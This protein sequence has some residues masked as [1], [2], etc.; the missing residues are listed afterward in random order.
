VTVHTWTKSACVVFAWS[1]LLI[2][3][4]TTGVTGPARPPEAN[5]HIAGKTTE[6]ILTSMSDA[7][8]APGPTTGYVV[9]PGDTLSSIAA[10]FAVRG[11]WP[12]LYA[13][14]RPLI[15]PDPNLIRPGA[16]LVLPGQ[17]APVRYR[18]VPGD[19]LAGIAAAL[20]VHGGWPALYAANRPLIGPDPNVIH[21]GAVLM[22]PRP[23]APSR[24]ASGPAP[25]RSPAPPSAPAHTRHNPLPGRTGAPV[26][27]GM[28]QWLKILLAAG[29]L[30]AAAFVAG[31]M[32]AVRRR[33]QTVRRAAPP[34]NAGSG[35]APGGERPD[36][37]TARIVV[38]D[39]DR[40]VVACNRSGGTA[41]VLRPPG[42]DPREILRVARLVLPQAWYA[43]LAGRL[44]FPAGWPIVVADHDRLVVACS[45]PGGTVY[46]LRPPGTDPREILRVARLVL[47][48]APY[49]ELAELLG[50]SAGWPVQHRVPAKPAGVLFAWALL[51]VLAVGAGLT[52]PTRLAKA[53]ARTASSTPEVTITSMPSTAAAPDPASGQAAGYVVQP[54]DTLPGIAAAWRGAAAGRR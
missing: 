29:L 45:Q 22:V 52:G 18:V 54:G 28:P 11:G 8:A 48:E 9:Q 30:A 20:A 40:L 32:L 19:T 21:P 44:G 13:A 23:K 14:N 17:Q 6:V 39:H 46:V 49:A 26:A 36:A 37:D 47:P 42:T 16:V 5:T 34:G 1:I 53:N 50:V 4:V 33:R 24:A 12:T 35:S 7:A 31:L 25:R 10:R 27:A 15:G 3:A 38:A 2:I 41:Y 51:L 43:E